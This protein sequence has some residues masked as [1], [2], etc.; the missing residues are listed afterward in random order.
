VFV[1]AAGRADAHIHWHGGFKH[2]AHN[3]GTAAVS[4]DLLISLTK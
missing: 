4:D 1:F 3:A 2:A